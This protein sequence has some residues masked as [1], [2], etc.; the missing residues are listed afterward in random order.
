[1]TCGGQSP[2]HPPVQKLYS[3][4]QHPFR[5]MITFISRLLCHRRP[6]AQSPAQVPLYTRLQ[7]AHVPGP[8]N[9]GTVAVHLYPGG[10]RVINPVRFNKRPELTAG[11]LILHV[12]SAQ[13]G[14][15]PHLRLHI[16]VTG[17]LNAGAVNLGMVIRFHS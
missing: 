14:P 16:V 3:P 8:G 13:E 7:L 9:V 15:Q 4:P 12:F 2:P 1:M 17:S 11:I 10:L 6:H 5:I